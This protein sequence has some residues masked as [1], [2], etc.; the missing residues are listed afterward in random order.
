MV[1]ALHADLSMP[2]STDQSTKFLVECA[3]MKAMT[4]A[5]EVLFTILPQLPQEPQPTWEDNDIEPRESMDVSDAE[6]VD[7]RWEEIQ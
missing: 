6:T 2:P 5:A 1:T 7:T 4:A 3:L